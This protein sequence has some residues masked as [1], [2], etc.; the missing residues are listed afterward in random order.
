MQAA[1]V[2]SGSL[3]T[4]I[5]MAGALWL[6][7][8]AFPPPRPPPT[9]SIWLF[10]PLSP[11]LHSLR[12]VSCSSA[13][14]S[15]LS[16]STLTPSPSPPG[17]LPLPARR[18]SPP[19]PPLLTRPPPRPCLPAAGNCWL[20]QAKNGRCQVL[21]KTE[22]TKEECCS[23]GRL[24]TSWTEEDVND[25]TLFKWMIFNGGAPN[26]IPCKGRAL[27]PQFVGPQ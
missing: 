4:D 17:L 3:V 25:N 23:T 15:R 8:L 5:D 1:R 22:L 13:F 11:P 16:S 10:P 19:T 12:F 9:S 27:P 26:C 6:L 24:S 20:R 7:A 2:V 18:L 14:L 21:Y